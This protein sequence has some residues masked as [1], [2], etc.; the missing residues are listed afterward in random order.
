MNEELAELAASGAT[1]LVSAMGTDLWQEAK[2]LMSGVLAQARGSRRTELSAAL[3]RQATADRG[4]VDAVAVG[5]WTEALSQLLDRNPAL[6]QDV[7]ALAS[8][9]T[10]EMPDIVIQVNSAT[11]SGGVFAVQH[12]TQH[13]S[14]GP[15]SR[16]S[17]ERP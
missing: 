14:S 15:N 1:A 9:R 12:G 17:E 8:L 4:A 5:Y 7:M 11:N 3:D 10:P 16:D 2:R 13:F 6:A